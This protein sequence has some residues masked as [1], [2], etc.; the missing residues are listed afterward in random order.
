MASFSP[1]LSSTKKMG[2]LT[3]PKEFDLYLLEEVLIAPMIIC[4]LP[5]GGQKETYA[6]YQ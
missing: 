4:E 3:K 5:V 2:F 1:K 6:M